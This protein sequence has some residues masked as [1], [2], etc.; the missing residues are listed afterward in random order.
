MSPSLHPD[1]RIQVSDLGEA[2]LLFDSG[3]EPSVQGQL[4]IRALAAQVGAWPYVRHVRPGVGNLMVGFDPE[5]TT[6]LALEPLLRA[7]WTEVKPEAQVGKQVDVPVR[8]GG[9]DGP[10]L[11]ELARAC[12]LTPAQAVQCHVDGKYVAAAIGALPGY[13]YLLGLDPRLNL[14]RR[15]S[16]RVS[17]PAGS[18]VIAGGMC[19]I[20]TR[21]SASGWHVIG[22]SELDFFDPQREPPVLIAP[23]DTVRFVAVQDAA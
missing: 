6:R 7:A 3:G 5:R 21:T 11:A 22:R 14:G 15:A 16:P 23:G 1:A 12:G 20:I 9:D 13:P 17:V 4:R 8:Y 18:I 10:D 19:G 2:A